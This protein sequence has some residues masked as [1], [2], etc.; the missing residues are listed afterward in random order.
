MS[1]K[2]VNKIKLKRDREI[3]DHSQSRMEAKPF[4]GLLKQNRIDSLF[5]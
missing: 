4:D 3:R 5:Y 1:K 2:V